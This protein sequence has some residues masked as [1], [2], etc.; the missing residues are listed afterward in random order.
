MDE[1][2]IAV[3]VSREAILASGIVYVKEGN[4]IHG[5]GKAVVVGDGVGLS[6]EIGNEVRRERR[7]SKVSHVGVSDDGE[8]GEGGCDVRQC[9]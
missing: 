6:E 3:V 7:K 9:V 2:R 8:V 1:G 4:A 5:F